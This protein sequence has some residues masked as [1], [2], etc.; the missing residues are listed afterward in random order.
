MK[1]QPT[2]V[3]NYGFNATRIYAEGET[4]STR[5]LAMKYKLMESAMKEFVFRVE[6]GEVRSRK[7]YKQ[8]KED[9]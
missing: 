1:K 7:T 2:I 8:F 9:T 5:V 6:K 4:Y 3:T